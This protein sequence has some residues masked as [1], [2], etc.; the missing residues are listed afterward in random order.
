MNP[1]L[2]TLFTQLVRNSQASVQPFAER[3]RDAD[4]GTCSS[5]VTAIGKLIKA[6]EERPF[7]K[8]RSLHILH[9]CMLQHNPAFALE[10]VK[11]LLS[12]LGSL[13]QFQRTSADP[14][15]GMSLFG[16]V[17]IE[18]QLDSAEFLR[19][20]LCCLRT[21]GEMFSQETDRTLALYQKT[22][23]T[24][25]RGGVAFPEPSVD[26]DE[27]AK[28][29]SQLER[30][31][32][33]GQ[34]TPQS[35]LH[36]ND[37]RSKTSSL[38]QLMQNLSKQASLPYKEPL[39]KALSVLER[40]TTQKES[41]TF[42][43]APRSSNSQFQSEKVR[44]SMKFE[45]KKQSDFPDFGFDEED[46]D[47]EFEFNDSPKSEKSP[48]LFSADPEPQ[49]TKKPDMA[50]EKQ[51]G[52]NTATMEFEF[53]D[54]Q[55][56]ETF[57]TAAVPETLEMKHPDTSKELSIEIDRLK[58]TISLKE[59]ESSALELE[60]KSLLQEINKQKTDIQTLLTEN[61]NYKLQIT[62]QMKTIEILQNQVNRINVELKTAKNAAEEEKMKVVSL[63]RK[64][65][66]MEQ[67]MNVKITELQ[68]TAE[69]NQKRLQNQ[70][71]ELEKSLIKAQKLSED[72]KATPTKSDTRHHSHQSSS[73]DI[74]KEVSS[75]GSDPEIP[76]HR[77]EL[78]ETN[79]FEQPSLRPSITSPVRD[80]NEAWYL[81]GLLSPQGVLY[82]DPGL[83]MDFQVKENGNVVLMQVIMHAK[84]RVC[85]EE[86]SVTQGF[87][88]S[89]SVDMKAPGCPIVIQQREMT[90]VLVRVQAKGF[91]ADSPKLVIRTASVAQGLKLP[92][93]LLRLCHPPKHDSPS[94]LLSALSPY[95]TS[96]DFSGLNPAFTKMAHIA[97]AISYEGRFQVYTSSKVPTL[98]R[99]GV[100][101]CGE[102]L[103]QDVAGKVVL[104][105]DASGGTI[106]ALA[107]SA[108]L[109]KELL[110]L[111]K[112][113]L[114]STQ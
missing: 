112:A 61:K 66:M 86:L 72:T 3:V 30:A 52:N 32:S 93:T 27:L 17:D 74:I 56:T 43:T 94:D 64:L 2:V 97:D 7:T 8:L 54:W 33:Q 70:I 51:D 1:D 109:R 44:G 102:C 96:E 39:S 67:N 100:M 41:R 80:V 9:A 71:S 87:A 46:E 73:S 47:D 68:K 21:W 10:T 91:F 6:E 14:N 95:S 98:G 53:D 48:G 23:L 99:T 20:L 19:V 88:D 84:V 90:K 55:G 34:F 114:V 25:H 83:K 101:L 24:L 5:V 75:E 40:Y 76:P 16:A 22:Y 28:D 77:S 11:K 62:E 65:E 60:N 50:S 18:E 92:I 58:S 113:T 29:V 105:P 111:L 49:F 59:Q 12:K 108:V 106:T 38:Q 107:S 31:I 103:S 85:I 26:M 45:E 42:F 110:A 13:G 4:E 15:R 81:S 89:C 35:D 57:P 78:R 69:N 63:E 104:R 37:L 36:A 79:P 82:E